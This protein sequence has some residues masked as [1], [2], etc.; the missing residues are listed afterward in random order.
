MQYT[1]LSTLLPGLLVASEDALDFGLLDSSPNVTPDDPAVGAI[2]HFVVVFAV[3]SVGAL[4]LMVT[5]YSGHPQAL[6][7]N[8]EPGVN[9]F[10][11]FLTLMS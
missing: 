1:M 3:A 2:I 11:F 4:A 8:D 7:E 5:D 10:L 9:N 6:A